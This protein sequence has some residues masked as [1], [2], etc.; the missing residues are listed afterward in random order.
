MVDFE[1]ISE[2]DNASAIAAK[3]ARMY[4]SKAGYKGLSRK[5]FHTPSALNKEVLSAAEREFPEAFAVT[6]AAQFRQPTDVAAAGS[7]YFNYA[8]SIG[9]AVPGSIK[10]D[11]IDPAVA[12]G[13]DRMA[14]VL[15]SRDKDCIV[16][17]DG[18]SP[19]ED[20]QRSSTDQFIRRSLA[21]LLPVRSAFER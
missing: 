16:I 6:S 17:N 4:L 11:Y 5:F 12:D 14:R 18:S 21:E 10:Y 2:V 20:A 7:F 19:E 3:N 8:L 15:K 1:D 9:K 13:R